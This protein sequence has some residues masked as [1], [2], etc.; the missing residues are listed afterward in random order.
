MLTTLKILKPRPL[1]AGGLPDERQQGFQIHLAGTP[2]P[3]HHLGIGPHPLTG[4][5][6]GPGAVWPKIHGGSFCNPMITAVEFR[7]NHG[8]IPSHLTPMGLFPEMLGAL[9]TEVAAF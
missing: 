4:L 8:G 7:K 9:G 3:Q 5:P 2:N 6:V 1:L